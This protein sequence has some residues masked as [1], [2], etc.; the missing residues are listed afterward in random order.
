M[1]SDG[2]VTPLGA[3]NADALQRLNDSG[4]CLLRCHS[5]TLVKVLS[6][7]N[8]DDSVGI[9]LKE[10]GGGLPAEMFEILPRDCNLKPIFT[11]KWVSVDMNWVPPPDNSNPGW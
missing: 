11:Q 8:T 1:A 3:V 6:C 10:L 2:C 9:D 4:R 7:F 5:D